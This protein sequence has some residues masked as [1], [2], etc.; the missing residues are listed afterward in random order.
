MTLLLSLREGFP[1]VPP[2]PVRQPGYL[3]KEARSFA[4]PPHNGFAVIAALFRRCAYCCFGDY[5]FDAGYDLTSIV[6]CIF[7]LPF[8]LLLLTGRVSL[9]EKPSH[10]SKVVS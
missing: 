2:Y 4:S 9:E 3:K 1:Q 10:P 6:L 5:A 8:P 7:L